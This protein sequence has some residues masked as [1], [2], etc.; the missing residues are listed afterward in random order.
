MKEYL[1]IVDEKGN[2]TGETVERSL[3]HGEG[4][5]HRTAHLWLIRRKEGSEGG[6]KGCEEGRSTR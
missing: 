4:I 3:A 2:P 5:R 6:A 1:D